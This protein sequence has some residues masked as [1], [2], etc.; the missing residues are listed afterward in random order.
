MEWKEVPQQASTVVPVICGESR[1]QQLPLSIP[2]EEFQPL[3]CEAGGGVKGR[4]SY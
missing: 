2:L 4:P 1:A 3:L